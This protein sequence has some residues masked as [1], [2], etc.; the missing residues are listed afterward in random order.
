[1]LVG[2]TV[3]RKKNVNRVWLGFSALLFA[4][5]IVF[6]FQVYFK[7][8]E[9]LATFEKLSEIKP[10]EKIVINFSTPMA[11]ASFEE[12]F[13]INPAQKVSFSWENGNKKVLISPEKY[14]KPQTSY[15][16]EI[17]NAKNIFFRD[18]EKSLNFKTKDFPRIVS[19]SPEN[20]Q[21]DVAV[22]IE[23]PVKIKFD[24]SLEGYNVKFVIT[25]N[26][27]LEW[28]MTDEKT[29]INLLA[30]ENFKW[31]TK[32][33]I[34]VFIKSNK[35]GSDEYI[36]IGETFFETR[37]L[38]I[39]EN[40]DKDPVARSLQAKKFT[41]AIIQDGKYIDINLSKQTMVI[42]ENGIALDGYLVSSGKVGM[43]TPV[44]SFKIE[45]KALRPWSKKYGL[46]MPNWMAILPSGLIGIHELPVWPGGFQEGANHLGIPVSHGCVRL[47]PFSAKRVFDWAEIGTPVVV[48]Q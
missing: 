44:G 17:R 6:P 23:D 32:Y 2:Y 12:S 38:P 13:S 24:R 39:P 45:N 19:F 16:V 40:W 35:Q 10:D 31:E 33:G 5:L 34:A 46:F 21:T 18:F 30:V 41:K 9:T 27:S 3:K 15:N 29:Q 42:F 37:T 25:P 11:R 4:V 20:G 1:M 26:E 14:W 36:K 8:F 22:D 43:E 48:H 28:Q 47:G 7:N